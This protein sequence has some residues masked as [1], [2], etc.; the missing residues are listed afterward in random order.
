MLIQDIESGGLKMPDIE[1]MIKAIKLTWIKRIAINV[2]SFACLAKAIMNIDNFQQFIQYK[3]DSKFLAKSMPNFYKQLFH[4]WYELHSR[5]PNTP[6][7]YLN[8]IIWNNKRILRDGQ[9][10]PPEMYYRYGIS[11][12]GDLLNEDGIFLSVQEINHKYAFEIDVLMYNGIKCAVP[13]LWIRAINNTTMQKWKTSEN[14]EVKINCVKKEFLKLKC[15]QLYSEF[16]ILKFERPSAL[17]KWEELYY[18][19]ELNW[20]HIFRLPYLIARETNLQSFQYQIINR[21]IPC[22]NNL[23]LWKK[24]PDNQCS[25]CTQIDTIE[26]YIYQ[27]Q[28]LNTFWTSLKTI[29]H[30]A[31]NINVQL[32]TLDILFGL[33][34]EN[35]DLIFEVFN[36]CIL[37]AKH[38]IYTCKIHTVPVI[39]SIFK[40]KIKERIDIE[41]FFHVEHEQLA[42]FENKWQP[43]YTIL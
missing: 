37:F 13:K 31:F 28:S 34:N 20:K 19:A 10:I 16:V 4:F 15:K 27:C 41:R 25:E 14:I 2:N 22:R 5:P 6:N 12:I 26:H 7:E 3:N 36:F 21:Y 9:P 29:L 33:L 40:N 1:A 17:Y 18:Y 23:Y 32:S 43:L 8:E 24:E 30:N 11:K 39:F 35:K 42:I 38:F